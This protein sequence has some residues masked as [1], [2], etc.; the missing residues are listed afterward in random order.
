MSS[1]L[2]VA[3]PEPAPNSSEVMNLKAGTKRLIQNALFLA[4]AGSYYYYVIKPGAFSAVELFLGA[5]LG[6]VGFWA[7]GN[8]GN[9]N[10]AMVR[11]FTGSWRML[12]Y[13]LMFA[14]YIIHFLL[15]ILAG[16]GIAVFFSLEPVSILFWTLLGAMAFEYEVKN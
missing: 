12:V 8:K 5:L 11:P 9:R 10:F 7:V 6:L 13:W 14:P 2:G 15:S 4:V 16:T 1:V 3:R